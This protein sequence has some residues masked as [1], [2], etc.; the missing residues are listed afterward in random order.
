MQVT[1]VGQHAQHVPLLQRLLGSRFDVLGM[2]QLPCSGEILTD[3]LVATRAA[4]AEAARLRCRLLQVPGVGLDAIALG[5][6]PTG[7]S[8]CTAYEHEIP[9]AEFVCHAVL[10]SAINSEQVPLLDAHSWPPRAYLERPLHGE[11][12][13]LRAAVVGFGAIGRACAARL[14]ALGLRVTA[15]TR[16]GESVEGAD[17]SH[18]VARLRALLPKVDV[19]LLCCPLNEKTRGLIGAREISAMSKRA[20][21]VNVGRAHLVQQRALFEALENR[22]IG[23]AVL[24]VWYE[25]PSGGQ[26][27]V[28]PA[29][30]PFHTLPNV[31][32]TP[33]IAGWTDGVIARRYTFIAENI[34]RLDTGRPLCNRVQ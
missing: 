31:R 23:G 29:S 22:R 21:L 26:D 33:H 18:P 12:C 16:R 1:V 2:S 7:C 13:G 20:L 19:L 24:D 9:I 32:C 17:A 6:V 27:L 14:R 8:V 15:V 28:A 3:V 30:W 10:E 34:R 11:V 25:Y 5:A 4:A